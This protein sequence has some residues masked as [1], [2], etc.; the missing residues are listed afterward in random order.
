MDLA[1]PSP[2][3]A[4]RNLIACPREGF[5]ADL[6]PAPGGWE[7]GGVRDGC[8]S[9][10][11]R[12]QCQPDAAPEAGADGHSRLWWGPSPAGA[13]N[14][15]IPCPEL[16]TTW[17]GHAPAPSAIGKAPRQSKG[18]PRS[19]GLAEWVAERAPSPSP[20]PR[21]GQI[22]KTNPRTWV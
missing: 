20:A 11:Q 9:P 6:A 21:R 2:S 22:S 14:S 15:I 3:K 5:P 1:R 12:P 4:A 16:G 13:F 19:E 18:H 7:A 17:G 8:A 10:P